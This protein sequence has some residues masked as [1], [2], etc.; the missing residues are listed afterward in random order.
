MKQKKNLFLVCSCILVVVLTFCSTEPEKTCKE[1]GAVTE[2]LTVGKPSNPNDLVR[3]FAGEMELVRVFYD[4]GIEDLLTL[5][6]TVQAGRH[7]FDYQSQL[8]PR[9]ISSADE[10]FAKF[11]HQAMIARRLNPDFT[12]SLNLAIRDV[13][14]ADLEE[15]TLTF[16]VRPGITISDYRQEGTIRYT[17]KD[18]SGS[19]WYGQYIIVSVVV[20]QNEKEAEIYDLLKTWMEQSDTVEISDLLIKLLEKI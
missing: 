12:I 13:E 4:P 10:T 20:T 6:G 19:F 15:K 18:A 7:Y 5:P 9:P 16:N 2:N 1:Q 3:D 17:L 14:A 8:Y 11:Q